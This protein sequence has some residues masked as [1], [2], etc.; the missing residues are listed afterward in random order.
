[1]LARLASQGDFQGDFFVSNYNRS[2]AA[3]SRKFS[4]VNSLP[5]AQ[6]ND[7]PVWGLDMSKD[8]E[9][10]PLEHVLRCERVGA[11]CEHNNVLFLAAGHMSYGFVV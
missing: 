9:A 11:V 2:P 4:G 10:V 3:R 8:N 1:M 7:S 5:C 6:A